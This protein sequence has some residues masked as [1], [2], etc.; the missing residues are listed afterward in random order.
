M[1]WCD[2]L[3]SGVACCGVVWSGVVWC[4]V[5][6]CVAEGGGCGRR[7]GRK[8]EEK[9]RSASLKNKNPRVQISTGRKKATAELSNSDRVCGKYLMSGSRPASPW[10]VRDPL[11]N[12]ARCA[13]GGVR[14]PLNYLA[15]HAHRSSGRPGSPRGGPGPPDLPCS[16]CA[17]EF[18]HQRPGSPRGGSGTP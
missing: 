16:P 13:N 9:Q 2:V 18:E 17:P 1:V 14:D 11:N 3:W 12:L 5:E 10:G 15:R 4:G 7:E 6:W 8:E